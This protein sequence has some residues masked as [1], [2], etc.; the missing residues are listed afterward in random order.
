MPQSR[1]SPT[2]DRT[3]RAASSDL[4]STAGPLVARWTCAEPKGSG[5]P[6]GF[7]RLG[8]RLPGVS[9]VHRRG[10]PALR[11]RLTQ[12]LPVVLATLA[13]FGVFAALGWQLGCAWGR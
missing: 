5:S 9:G 6:G 8:S 4:R 1:I 13:I 3:D 12:D 11:S 2:Q 7:G 10:V